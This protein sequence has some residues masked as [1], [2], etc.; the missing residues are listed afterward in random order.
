MMNLHVYISK[1]LKAIDKPYKNQ[2]ENN[3]EGNKGLDVLNN[4]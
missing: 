4:Q 1:S 2:I 3:K